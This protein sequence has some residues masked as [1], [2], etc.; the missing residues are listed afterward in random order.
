M[1]QGAD[2]ANR[3]RSDAD[4]SMSVPCCTVACV[5]TRFFVDETKAKGYV[6]V[7]VACPEE[8][9]AGVRREVGRLILPGQRAVHMN[10]EGARRRRRIADAVA[11]LS[12]HG[13]TSSVIAVAGPGS[14][15][16]RRDLALSVVVDVAARAPG[17]S[18]VL[19]LDPTVMRRTTRF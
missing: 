7:A 1:A 19:D 6:V 9:I 5:G 15:H 17:P 2:G 13:V 8:S 11:R 10:N 16:E 4:A 18:L 3:F 14:E 12:R